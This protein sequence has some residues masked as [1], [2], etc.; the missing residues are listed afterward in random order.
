MDRAVELLRHDPA[1]PWTF[2]EL[3]ASVPTSVRSLQ[4]GFRRALDTTPMAYLRRLRLERARE[5]LLT[6]RPGSVT[7]R[8]RRSRPAGASCTSA[9][10]RGPTPSGSASGRRRRCGAPGALTAV[11]DV[12]A[13]RGR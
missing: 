9:G 13:R 11:A 8:S 5:D 4:E 12:A 2:G 3:A 1:R 10:S 7:S 6:A